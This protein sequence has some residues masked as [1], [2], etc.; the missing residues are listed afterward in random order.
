MARVTIPARQRWM[1]GSLRGFLRRPVGFV[2]DLVARTNLSV[3]SKILLSL[4]IVILIM[5]ITNVALVVQVLNY[6]RQYDAIIA[7]I[8]TA[9]SIGGHIKPD[10]D[11]EMW[12]IVAGKIDFSEGQQYAILNDVNA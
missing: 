1:M 3:R 8:T 9:N 5:S 7:N 11:M 6:S 2:A 4:C 10:I 12:R